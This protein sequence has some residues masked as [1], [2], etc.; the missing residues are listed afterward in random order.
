MN[1]AWPKPLSVIV[2]RVVEPSLKVTPPVGM[3][4]PGATGTTVAVKVTDWPV[5]DGFWLDDRFAVVIAGATPCESG[6]EVLMMKLP[7]PV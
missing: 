6:A 5:L 3:P 1:V 2:P 4:A 7:S